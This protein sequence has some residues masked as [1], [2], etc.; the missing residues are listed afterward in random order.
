MGVSFFTNEQVCDGKTR[1]KMNQERF[2]LKLNFLS[3][4]T[5]KHWKQLFKE[6]FRFFSFVGS[7]DWTNN[8]I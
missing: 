1:Q 2:C 5:V 7:N 8:L 4:R 6:L 3:A